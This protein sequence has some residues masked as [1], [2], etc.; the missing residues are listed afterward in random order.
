MLASGHLIDM[1]DTIGEMMH[2][3]TFMLAAESSIQLVSTYHLFAPF[4]YM[5]KETLVACV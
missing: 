3:N 2:A 5:I 4:Q 1:R